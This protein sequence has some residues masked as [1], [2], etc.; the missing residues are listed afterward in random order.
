VTFT[1][2]DVGSVGLTEA[3]AR[4]RW[5]HRVRVADLDSGSLDRAITAGEAYGFVKLVADPRDRPVGAT[6]AAPGGGEAVAELTAWASRGARITHASCTVHAYPTLAEG[7][8][9]AAGAHL[10]ARYTSP[11]LRALARPVL[12]ALRALEGPR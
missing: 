5:G 3:R 7:P 8:A 9:R 11:R 12:A 10:I 1:D 4:T 2:P 6:V